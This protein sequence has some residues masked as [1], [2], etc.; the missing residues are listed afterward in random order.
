MS[1]VGRLAQIVGA[2]VRRVPSGFGFVDVHH[3][4]G[5]ALHSGS[6]SSKDQRAWAAP[7]SKP[8]VGR[9]GMVQRTPDGRTR[10]EPIVS[11]TDRQA[12]EKWSSAVVE[13]LQLAEPGMLE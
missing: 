4:S 7:P 6:I 8:I 13:A 10:Y 9:D 11:F 3:L 12:K 1:V 5:L 2:N